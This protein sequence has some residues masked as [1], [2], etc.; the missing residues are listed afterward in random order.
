MHLKSE[1]RL[2]HWGLKVRRLLLSWNDNDVVPA[3]LSTCNMRKINVKTLGVAYFL[4]ISCISAA[5]NVLKSNH[6]LFF[7]WD[8]TELVRRT[9]DSFIPRFVKSLCSVL[10]GTRWGASPPHAR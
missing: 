5:G 2:L 3:I 7:Y 10:C 8:V 9:V 4:E 6:F 1:Q